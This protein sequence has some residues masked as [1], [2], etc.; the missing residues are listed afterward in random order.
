MRGQESERS[1]QS[2]VDEHNKAERCCRVM[3]FNFSAAYSIVIC[4]QIKSVV[5]HSL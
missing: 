4:V 5:Q 2:A 1:L 3:F